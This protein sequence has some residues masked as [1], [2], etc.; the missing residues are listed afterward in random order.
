MQLL[1]SIYLGRVISEFDKQYF[2]VYI[3]SAKG[4]EKLVNS[5]EEYERHIAEGSWFAT[6]AEADNSTLVNKVATDKDEKVI[7]YKK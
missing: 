3:Y 4:S 7:R 5:W 6:K 1:P 2:R